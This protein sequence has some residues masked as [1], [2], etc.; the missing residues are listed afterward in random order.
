MFQEQRQ[1]AAR[2]EKFV[3]SADRAFTI[4]TDVPEFY[5]YHFWFTVKKLKKTPFNEFGLDDKKFIVDVEVFR[6]ILDIC[7]RCL[8]FGRYAVLVEV[9]TAYWEFSWSRDHVQYLLESSYTISWIQNMMDPGY[10]V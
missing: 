9:N 5:M 10:G 6:E 1:Q 4:T 8:E 3:P 7:P 2:E